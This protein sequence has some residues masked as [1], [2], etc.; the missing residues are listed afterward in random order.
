VVLLLENWWCDWLA[1]KE[2]VVGDG[3]LRRLDVGLD[4][5]CVRS[6]GAGRLGWHRLALEAEEDEGLKGPRREGGVSRRI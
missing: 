1:G 4:A 6:I 3:W 5:G 2:R